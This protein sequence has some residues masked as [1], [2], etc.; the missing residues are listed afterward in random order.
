M[1]DIFISYAREDLPRVE[2]IVKALEA[3]GLSVWWDRR[4]LSG[5][6]FDQVIDK[7]LAAAKCVIVIWSTISINSGFV[8]DEAQVGNDRNILVPAKIDSVKPPLGFRRVQT[9]DLTDWE[10]ETEH[11]G[12]VG[13]IDSI[14]EKIKKGHQQGQDEREQVVET[15]ESSLLNQIEVHTQAGEIPRPITSHPENAQV[16]PPEQKTTVTTTT[17]PKSSEPR[18]TNNSLKLI[19]VAG[20]I[21]IVGIGLILFFGGFPKKPSTSAWTG[22]QFITGKA[23][24]QI[25]NPLHVVTLEGIIQTGY[26]PLTIKAGKLVSNNARI[27][28]SEPP[29]PALNGDTGRNGGNGGPA[30]G[31]GG[32]GNLGDNGGAGQSGK[33]GVN[34]GGISIDTVDFEGKLEI[35]NNGQPGGNGGKGGKGGNGS[36]GNK[37]NG[38][39]DSLVGCLSSGQDGGNGGKGGNGGNGGK[40]GNGGNG[41]AININVQRT[42]Q[43]TVQLTA[44]GGAGGNGSLGGDKGKGGAGGAGGS[45]SVYC[46]GGNGGNAN[47]YGQDGV[48]G[49]N[50]NLGKPGPLLLKINEQEIINRI[51]SGN[52]S[53]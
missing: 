38:G 3:Q 49:E 39:V 8:K 18:K 12:F 17:E 36:P 25:G 31:A 28:S 51:G 19:A 16:K 48:Q 29:N 52:Y 23:S 10:T 40:G 34:A 32:Y 21:V 1:S 2:S 46:K 11:A 14:S 7:E 35:A 47:T 41:G 24:G 6:I 22:N 4:I 15:P 27:V 42:F 50:G 5:E 20:V 44:S 33:D 43:G 13:F 45:G 30:I 26:K 53:Q 37:G 9:A